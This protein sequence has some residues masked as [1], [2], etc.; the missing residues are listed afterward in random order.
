MQ[1][2][3]CRRFYQHRQGDWTYAAWCDECAPHEARA[4]Q[5]KLALFFPL[6]LV[7]AWLVAYAIR[8]LP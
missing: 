8:G 6:S 3:K 1:C 5:I 7:V 2:A 4:D